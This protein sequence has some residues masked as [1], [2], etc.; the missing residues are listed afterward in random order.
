MVFAKGKNT[1]MKIGSSTQTHLKLGNRDIDETNK[2]KYIRHM[3]NN[4]GNLEDHINMLEGKIEET[5]FF[6]KEAVTNV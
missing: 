4:K 3:I 6:Y 2:Y 1:A 5:F